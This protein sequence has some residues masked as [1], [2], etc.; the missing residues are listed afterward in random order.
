MPR[1]TITELA[2]LANVTEAAIRYR[3]RRRQMSP[4]D[5]DSRFDRARALAELGAKRRQRGG[6]KSGA[7]NLAVVAPSRPADP[8]HRFRLARAQQED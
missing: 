6:R 4:P 1:L 2:A 3:V 5:R 8:A 7:T